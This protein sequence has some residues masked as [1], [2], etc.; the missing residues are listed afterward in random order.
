VK[1]TNKTF[2]GFLVRKNSMEEIL[3]Q[4]RYAIYKAGVGVIPE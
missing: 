2:N 3:I 4:G 1:S